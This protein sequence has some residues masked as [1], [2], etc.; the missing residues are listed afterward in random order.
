MHL[1]LKRLKAP[2]SL[3]VRWGGEELWNVEHKEG[4]LGVG[5]GMEY[6]L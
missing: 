5:W 3:E 4:G 1:P 6:R 2:G